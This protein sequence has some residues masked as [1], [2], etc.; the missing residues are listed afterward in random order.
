VDRIYRPP[1]AGAQ[2]RILPGAHLS[3]A[4]SCLSSAPQDQPRVVRASREEEGHRMSRG[5]R[6]LRDLVWREIIKMGEANPGFKAVVEPLGFFT[7]MSL[8]DGIADALTAAQRIQTETLDEM[9]SANRAVWRIG[10]EVGRTVYQQAGE[11]PSDD[12][13]LIGVMDTPRLALLAAEAVNRS[14]GIT[15]PEE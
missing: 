8:V 12:D 4:S 5:G 13:A 6:D 1:E 15:H 9:V 2:V 3:P 7:F 11:E 14:S 10:R